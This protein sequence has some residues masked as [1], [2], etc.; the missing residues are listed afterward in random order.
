MT[1]AVKIFLIA[2]AVLASV[3][4]L[5]I[6]LFIAPIVY[7][8]FRS[9]SQQRAL[10]NRSDYP[11]IA[12]ECAALARAVTNDSGIFWPEAG[13]VSP[14]LQSL[15]PQYISAYSNRVTM[16]FHGGFDHYGYRVR[17]C[18]TNPAQWSISYYTEHSEK[19]LATVSYD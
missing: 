5:A 10:Q 9:A 19:F 6:G 14:F 2:L 16:E 18:D 7:D 12:L 17:Q 1:R 13:G 8:V 11:K 3:A 4:L 15:S